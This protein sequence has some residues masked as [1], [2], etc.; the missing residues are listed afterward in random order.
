MAPKIILDKDQEFFV[1]VTN[2]IIEIIDIATFY[3]QGT[4]TAEQAMSMI[5]SIITEGKVK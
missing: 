5:I 4:I 1:K 2:Q 3:R